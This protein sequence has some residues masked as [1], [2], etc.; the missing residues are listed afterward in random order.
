MQC[1][2][3][4]LTLY[5]KSRTVLSDTHIP[6]PQYCLR[7]TPPSLCR[8]K[9]PVQISQ[10]SLDFT[11]WTFPLPL[12]VFWYI[13]SFP[14]ALNKLPL[15]TQLKRQ[16]ACTRYH[17]KWTLRDL[18][19]P[20]RCQWDLC[21]FWNVTQRRLLFIDFRRNL[22]FPPSKVKQTKKIRLTL[23]DVIGRLSRNV[24]ISSVKSRKNDTKRHLHF[25][26]WNSFKLYLKFQFLLHENTRSLA[27][28]EVYTVV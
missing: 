10:I 7:L 21:L 6:R 18:K 17:R 20:S 3:F 12:A 23:K 4:L 22:P 24:G 2:I 8:Q 11:I 28:L 15:P 19:R 26:Y 9:Q 27:T 1:H 16:H 14:I 25:E 13:W 5:V